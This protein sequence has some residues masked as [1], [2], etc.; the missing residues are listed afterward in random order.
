MSHRSGER[1]IRVLQLT[2]VETSNYYLNSLADHLHPGKVHFVAVTLGKAGGFVEELRQRGVDARGLGLGGRLSLLSAVVRVAAIA[3]A[4]RIQ[5][6]HAHLFEPSLL[7][8]V[9]CRVGNWPLVLT[10]HH[11]DAV[12]RLRGRLRRRVYGEMEGFINRT[13]RHIIA[14]AQAVRTVLTATE[15]VAPERVSVIPYPQEPARFSGLR[16]ADEV[17]RTLGVTE[18]RLLVCLSR[19]HPEKGLS[20]LI[21]ALPSLP[22][23]VHLIVIG[24]GSERGAL[25][26]LAREVGIA[27]RLNFLG[28]RT[29][30]LSILAAADLVVHP[31]HHEALPSAVIEALALGRPIVA[32]DVSGVRDILGDSEFGRVVPPGD[33]SALAVA[34]ADVLSRIEEARAKAAA[35][36]ARLFEYMNP[37]RVAAAHLD[38]YRGTLFS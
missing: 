38:C 14:P 19:L 18:G 2:A 26:Q 28:W 29:D 35:G 30:A 16:A 3:A 23:D 37:D 27:G 33:L 4:Q 21:K 34:L 32:S 5:I 6:V 7:G 8:S 15:G 9:V 17:R 11:S 24:T 10:R 12:H 36:K 13:A 22:Q 20:T 25:E 1:P 31:S